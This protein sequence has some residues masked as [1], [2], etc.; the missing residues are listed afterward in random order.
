MAYFPETLIATRF[1]RE[2]GGVV[3]PNERDLLK[4]IWRHP[5]LSR[6]EV[7]AHTDLTQQSVYRIIDQLEE[8]GI[9]SFGSPKPG[10]GRGQPSPTLR[11]AGSYAYTCGISVNTDVIGICLMD[12]A[13]NVLAESSVALRERTMAQA[14]DLV[15]QQL[16]EHQRQN[17]L[18]EET[19]FGIGFAIA[20]FHISGTRYNA[21]LP[22]HEWSLIELGPLLTELFNKPVWV[23]NGGKTG[24]IAES[25]FG[26]GRYI[27]HFAYLSFNYGFGGG[28][29]SDGELLL[30]GLGNAGEFSGMYD[31]EETKRRPALQWLIEKLNRN[32]VDVPSITYMRKYFDPK[33]PGVAEW[34]D[35]VTPA[36]NR[37]INAIWAIFDPQAIVFGGQVP[38]ALAQMLIDRTENF[39]RPRYGVPRFRPKLIISEISSDASAM[40]AAI[41]PFK[42]AYY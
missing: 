12:L 9:V 21:S 16:I 22:L 20:G 26:V 18:S 13:G 40:G 19:F 31:A 30:G 11:L 7:T 41:T 39:D 37:L 32:G 1:L 23:R 24:A 27:K 33:W 4:L 10:A 17:N 35:E 28:L 29:I 38:A 36:Y 42:S 5:G 3:S 2:G 14:L 8:R 6:S 34:V 25:M 15:R